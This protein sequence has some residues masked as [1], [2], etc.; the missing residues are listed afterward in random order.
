CGLLV[1]TNPQNTDGDATVDGKEPEFEEKK[2]ESEVNV[3]P[4][5]SA[6]PKKQDDKK[7]RDAKGKS[8]DVG[9]PMNLFHEVMDTCTALS[10]RVD[11]LELDKIAQALEITKL[12]RTVKKLERRNKVKV[13]EL[14]RLQ[15]E[16]TKKT[17]SVK[18]H[19][20]KPVVEKAS[21]STPALKPNASK[22]RPSKASGKVVKVCKAKSPF[23]LVNEP[24]KEPAHS[25]PELKLVHQEAT[26]PLLVVEGK[27]QGK[28]VDDQV[29]L[30]EKTVKLDQGKARSDHGR[31]PESRPPPEQEVIDEDQAGPDPEK[32]VRESLKFP[33]DEHVMLEEPLSS[34]GT[35]SSMKNLDDAYTIG[36]QFINDKSIKDKPDD[37]RPATLEPDWVIPSSHIPDVVNN[38]ANALATTYQAPTENSLL[39]KIGD[40]R[41]FMHY[42]CQQMGKTELTQANFKGQAYEVVKAFYPDVIQLQF[43]M[44]ECHKMLTDQIDWANLKEGS[45]Q[46]LSISKMKVARYLDFGL[47]LLVLEHIWINELVEDFQLDIESYQKQLN[48]TKPGWD[49]KGFDDGTLTNIM[50]ALDFRVKE[51]KVN[52][53]NRGMN[54]RFCTDKDVARSK[55]FIH[56]IE[57][58]LKT[59]RIFQNLKCFVGGHV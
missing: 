23:Q 25:E 18:Q 48:L 16:G 8:P 3:S 54:T 33:A 7:K 53:L 27:E 42:Y 45:K 35:L 49:A 20:S 55:E 37:E 51:Y 14:R 24:N 36:D 31:T 40:M 6:Q 5:S 15:K 9:L 19:K 28:D 4:S 59:R 13:L 22:E 44:E 52:W 39:E 1:F 34:S 11:H 41:T 38:W 12:K 58:R 30:D 2:P 29:N 32:A 17:V 50:E 43:Q 26:R 10:K 57:Q 46:A 21:K 47:E 56:A